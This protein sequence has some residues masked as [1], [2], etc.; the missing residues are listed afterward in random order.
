MTD[1]HGR[2][3]EGSESRVAPGLLASEERLAP[4][5][6]PVRRY[7]GSTRH[8]DWCFDHDHAGYCLDRLLERIG[9]NPDDDPGTTRAAA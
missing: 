5:A 2:N 4:S 9:Y 3:A 7:D 8:A 6:S 1:S